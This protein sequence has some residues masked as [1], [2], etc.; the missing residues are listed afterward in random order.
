MVFSCVYFLSKFL[1]QCFFGENKIL[2]LYSREQKNFR[3]LSLSRLTTHI[4][5][6]SGSEK[7]IL[8][9]SGSLET[10]AVEL[11]FRRERKIDKFKHGDEWKFSAA[12]FFA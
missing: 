12:E 8:P 6:K 9:L 2:R 4:V 1:V 7:N 5:Y 3:R 10:F 11:L